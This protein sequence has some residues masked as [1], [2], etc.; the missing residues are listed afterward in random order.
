[1]KKDPGVGM[2]GSG[3]EAGWPGTSA[4]SAT[5]A[6]WRCSSAEP[7]HH[8]HLFIYP[9]ATFNSVQQG[10]ALWTSGSEQSSSFLGPEQCLK[11]FVWFYFH[12]NEIKIKH[13]VV[14]KWYEPKSLLLHTQH[15]IHSI[16][17]IYFPRRPPQNSFMASQ[18]D[19]SCSVC[20]PWFLFFDT[21]RSYF[22]PFFSALLSNPSSH[23][24][25]LHWALAFPTAERGAVEGGWA[26]VETRA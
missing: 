23:V 2:Y 4:S 21:L 12:C 18:V 25:L 10:E 26:A 6:C 7:P 11:C 13:W 14:E 1:M 3:L 16:R 22:S 9:E 24:L 20:C 8:P 19:S 15:S 17:S 5:W